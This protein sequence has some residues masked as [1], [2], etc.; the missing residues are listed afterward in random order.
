MFQ[1][2]PEI[3]FTNAIQA[4]SSSTA[5]DR[6]DLLSYDC[7]VLYDMVQNVNEAQKAKFLALFDQGI[8]LVVT[9]HALV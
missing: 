7:I 3:T 1:D 2:N 6:E 9:H 8:G 5:Y 4:R